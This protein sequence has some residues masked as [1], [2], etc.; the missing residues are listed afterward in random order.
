MSNIEDKAQ[1]RIETRTMVPPETKA[2]EFIP[3]VVA[4]TAPISAPSTAVAPV[5]AVELAPETPP[6]E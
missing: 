1:S 2:L 3:A 6:S 5:A 4:V